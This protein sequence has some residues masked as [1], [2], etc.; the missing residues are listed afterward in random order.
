[1]PVLI[2][3]IVFAAMAAAIIDIIVRDDSQVKHMPKVVW[4]LL[5]I[6]LPLLGTI[7][8]FALGREYDGA[9]VRRPA[10]RPSSGVGNAAPLP[11][12]REGDHRSTEQQL[13]DL[14]KEIEVERLRAEI[15]RRKAQ[16]QD[17]SGD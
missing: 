6:L 8:W 5:V 16:Q 13:A 10:R 4:L 2:S 1:M 7:L 9:P 14:E 12:V 17:P 15:A 11:P 3:F